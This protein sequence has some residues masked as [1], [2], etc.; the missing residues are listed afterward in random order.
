VADVQDIKLLSGRV[1]EYTREW[2]K[3]APQWQ[4]F[5]F[6]FLRSWGGR[7]GPAL[8]KGNWWLWFTSIYVHRDL[9]H[10]VSN[11]L[12]F[13]AMSVH[14]ELNYGWWR[15]LLVWIMSGAYHAT[16]VS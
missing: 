15:L 1:P 12:L 5:N 2:L 6:E 3:W 7:W 16:A 11:L 14:L 4:T 9:Q 13:V 8:K 10:I